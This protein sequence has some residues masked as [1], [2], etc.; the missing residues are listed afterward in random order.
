M[1]HDSRIVDS[2]LVA[3]SQR[4]HY[5]AASTRRLPVDVM[6][7]ILKVWCRVKSPTLSVDA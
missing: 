6:A 1:D 5:A 7:G 2:S 3:N 4:M